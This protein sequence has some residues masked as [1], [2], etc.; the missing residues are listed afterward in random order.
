M[1]NR[2]WALVEWGLTY[3]L[4]DLRILF[5]LMGEVSYEQR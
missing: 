5:W 1:G 3:M 2:R 4:L